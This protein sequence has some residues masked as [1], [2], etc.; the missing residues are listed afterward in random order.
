MTE[1]QAGVRAPL[2]ARSRDSA[3]RLVDAALRV[4][5]RDGVQGLTMAAVSR[6]SGVSNGSLYHRYGGRDQLLAA[7][8]ERFFERVVEERMTAGTALM[9][10]KDPRVLLDL[11][12]E[13]FDEVFGGQRS[14]FQA[15][16]VAGYSNDSLR[17]R[18]REFTRQAADIFS[19]LLAERA[20]CSH[21]AGDMAY[22]LLLSRS[23]LAVMFD[24][25]EVASLTIPAE[26]QRRYARDAAAAILGL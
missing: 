15:F 10:E 19:A 26:T 13:G 4:L 16:I 2:Q 22:R 18:G 9:E 14:L 8:Q 17:A 24:E 20:G 6:E 5:A 3:R 12:I 1:P 23:M 7:C 11:L 25:L 21:E